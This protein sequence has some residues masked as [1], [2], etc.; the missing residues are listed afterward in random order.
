MN[1]LKPCR[2]CGVLPHI[3]GDR[4]SAECIECGI[5]LD[6]GE[7]CKRDIEDVWNA[8]YGLKSGERTAKQVRSMIDALH[9][10]TQADGMQ[11]RFVDRPKK[12]LGAEMSEYHE[13]NECFIPGVDP[14]AYENGKLLV[15]QE[16]C[17]EKYEKEDAP[18][19]PKH[20]QHPLL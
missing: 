9:A 16:I 1:D 20:L 5:K 15:T 2:K 19:W 18:I 4:R 3:S 17:G 8:C 12:E 6:L 13:M 14:I 7:T 11:V 10:K